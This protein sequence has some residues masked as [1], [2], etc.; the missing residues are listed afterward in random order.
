MWEHDHIHA[1]FK[2][3]LLLIERIWL[4]LFSQSAFA[5]F[6]KGLDKTL[7]RNDSVTSTIINSNLW[8][9]SRIL[10]N[11]GNLA[12]FS[13]T[14]TFFAYGISRELEKSSN[15]TGCITGAGCRVVLVLVWPHNPH[16]CFTVT[17][18]HNK[19]LIRVIK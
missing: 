7:I 16:A 18:K 5:V 14:S 6:K 19:M 15:M 17:T 10:L 13:P 3:Y 4:D 1:L 11:Y 8:L 12:S 9:Y 2:K